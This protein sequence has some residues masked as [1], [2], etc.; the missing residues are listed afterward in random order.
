MRQGF[1]V[2]QLHHRDTGL[3][4]EGGPTLASWRG[5]LGQRSGAFPAAVVRAGQALD[6]GPE[7]TVAVVASDGAG[8]LLPEPVGAV[9]GAGAAVFPPSENDYS[10]ALHLRFG[11]LDYFL[12]GD[13][14]GTYLRSGAVSYHDVETV[15][16][17]RL[18]DMDVYRVNHHGSAF[19]S[20]PTFL[21]QIDPLVAI[22]S[23]GRGSPHGHPHRA[24]LDRLLAT[25]AVFLTGGAGAAWPPGVRGGAPEGVVLRSLDGSHYTVDGQRF[26]ADDP[27]RVDADGDGYFREVDPDDADPTLTPAPSGGCDPVYQ[28]CSAAPFD[29]ALVTGAP[30]D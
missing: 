22:V 29:Q 4:G 12:G 5:P 10:V 25:G 16:A 11:R 28:R 14:S 26:T 9:T 23:A 20:N 21:G 8:A 24:T 17:R 19:S 15:V 6:L 3:A 2:G 7:L 27:P 13:L 1:R 30:R 18:P